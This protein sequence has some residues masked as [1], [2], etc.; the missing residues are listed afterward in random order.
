MKNDTSKVFESSLN[1]SEYNDSYSQNFEDYGNSMSVA[2]L[3][4][5]RRD[6]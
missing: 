5:R 1:K 4:F 3:D 6:S 2:E